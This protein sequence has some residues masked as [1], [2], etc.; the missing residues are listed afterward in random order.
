MS[1]RTH[2]TVNLPTELVDRIDKTVAE[3]QTTTAVSRDDFVRQAV[4]LLFLALEKP[5]TAVRPLQRIQ[6]AVDEARV[7]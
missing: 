7:K 6:D 5:I 2:K 4:N 1:R 3:G